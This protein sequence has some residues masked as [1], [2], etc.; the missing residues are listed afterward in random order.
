MAVT[1]GEV[2]DAIETTLATASGINTT[3]S[4]DELAE[5]LNAADLPLIQVYWQDLMMDPTGG[6]DR[7]TF[8][9]G[10]RQKQVTIY[11]DV[12]AAQRSFLWQDMKAVVDAVDNIL[13]VLESQNTVPYFGEAG[14]RS[15][16]LESARRAS[17][18]YS[19]AWYVVARF[20]FT[21]WI[22]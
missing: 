17:I 8:Q 7:T 6:T 19:E 12:Y 5:G 11:A 1:I 22:Y 9:A 2:C 20:S 13:V 18:Q 14:I 10:V 21:V 15:W 16:Q 3:Q 4:Y